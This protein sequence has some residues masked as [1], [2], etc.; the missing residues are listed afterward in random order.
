MCP[1][2]EN[3]IEFP[4]RGGD[5]KSRARFRGQLLLLFDPYFTKST[6]PAI[7]TKNLIFSINIWPCAPVL[8]T[9]LVQGA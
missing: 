2:E 9:T 6:I 7:G 8:S 5:I 1:H 4:N 3:A